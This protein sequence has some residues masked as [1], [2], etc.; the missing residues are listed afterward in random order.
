MDWAKLSTSYYL[1]IAVAQAGEAAEVLFIRCI[2]YSGAQESAGR[3]PKVVLSML[4]PTK[5]PARVAALV[6]EGLLIDNGNHVV[7]RSWD[8]W[9]QSL[10]KEADRKRKDRERKADVR[11]K[12]AQMSVD[13]PADVRGHSGDSPVD[14]SHRDLDLDVESQK[15]SSAAPPRPTVVDSLFDRFWMIYPRHEAKAAARKA[16]AK[17]VKLAEPSV[18]LEGANRYRNDPNRDPAFTA[19]PSTWLNKGQW[20]DEPL[21]SQQPRLLAVAGNPNNPHKEW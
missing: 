1:D 20:D 16:F 19:H 21:P 3:I 17:A 8:I 9:Q 18:I 15:R 12:S 2:A 5:T 10:D 7:I 11:A 14:P 4:A 6:R 13:I